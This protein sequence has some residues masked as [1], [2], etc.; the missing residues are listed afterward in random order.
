MIRRNVVASGVSGPTLTSP[1]GSSGQRISTATSSSSSSSH[2]HSTGHPSN[3]RPR[4][5]RSLT[6]IAVAFLLIASVLLTILSFM[7]PN[8]AE[9]VEQE[10]VM[11]LKA[12]DELMQKYWHAHHEAVHAAIPPKTIEEQQQE[13]QRQRQ[14]QERNNNGGGGGGGG[15]AHHHHHVQEEDVY[16]AE[17]AAASDR[18]MQ[19]A[20]DG[21]WVAG[22]KKL[23]Q[24]L[25]ILAERQAQGLDL[26]VPVLT[27]WLGED[28]PAWPTQDET[29]PMPLQ[30]WQKRVEEKYAQM[31]NE[32]EAWRLRMAD[33]IQ[34][35][36]HG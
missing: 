35:V 23:K 5:Q 31:R 22:E 24:R 16:D 13:Q 19:Q 1:P 14:E 27:R 21:S 18:R 26:G 8:V 20:T 33:L 6:D 2:L 32:E 25:K 34:N 30:E 28:I 10:A 29:N 11:I 17:Q 4:Q 7:F 3:T 15:A 36:N 12:E 9:Q